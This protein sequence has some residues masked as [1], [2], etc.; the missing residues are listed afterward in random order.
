[1]EE[2]KPT[3]EQVRFAHEVFNESIVKLIYKPKEIVEAF[4]ALTG[5]KAALVN[6]QYA[7]RYLFGFFRFSKQLELYP[8]YTFKDV[9]ESEVVDTQTEI[10]F[11]EEVKPDVKMSDVLEVIE[12]GLDLPEEEVEQMEA[13]TERLDQLIKDLELAT[14]GNDQKMIKSIKIKIGLLKKKMNE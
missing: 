9:D 13:D 8:D 4:R 14:G 5:D 11:T 12:F 7:H 2:Y 10:D 6:Y 3:L 1:M